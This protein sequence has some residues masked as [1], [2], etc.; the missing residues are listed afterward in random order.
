MV[1]AAEHEFL[2]LGADPPVGIPLLALREDCKQI[3]TALEAELMRTGR[4]GARGHIAS[5]LVEVEQGAEVC[6]STENPEE[7]RAFG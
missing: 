6:I 2:M 3:V 7:H 4:F 5:V 1:G